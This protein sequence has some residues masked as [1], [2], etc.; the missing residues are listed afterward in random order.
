MVEPYF[1]SG[2]GK[3]E[4]S[5]LPS[6]RVGRVEELDGPVLLLASEA[7]SFIKGAALPGGNGQVRQLP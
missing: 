2:Q 7:S 6:T 1:Q 3:E 5:H 4:I